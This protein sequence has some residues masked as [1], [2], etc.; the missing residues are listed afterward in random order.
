MP[1]KTSSG[2][3]DKKRK[4]LNELLQQALESG[5]E[6]LILTAKNAIAKLKPKAGKKGR[7][8][9]SRQNGIAVN[10]AQ[11]KDKVGFEG[12][13]FNPDDYADKFKED[14]ELDKKVRFKASER[15]QGV[16]DIEV[17]C[18]LCNRRE[19]LPGSYAAFLGDNRYYVC[20]RHGATK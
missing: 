16:E 17:T 1:T 4:L 18:S 2:G 19:Y 8:P 11:R 20:N 10:P 13:L 3:D 14:S 15:R 6:D 9:K 12:N 7:P 5:D